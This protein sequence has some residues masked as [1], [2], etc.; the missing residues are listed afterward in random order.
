MGTKMHD[1]TYEALDEMIDDDSRARRAEPLKFLCEVIEPLRDSDVEGLLKIW[2]TKATF[3]RWY[4]DDAMYCF[5]R[6]LANPPADLIDRI[7]EGTGFVLNH[8]E[9]AKVT[10]YAHDEVVAWLK[11]LRDK[12]RAI[13]DETAKK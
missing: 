5:D 6:V 1:K 3:Y 10:P 2:R 4:A 7:R 12:M 13:Y 11:E 9:F 8:V